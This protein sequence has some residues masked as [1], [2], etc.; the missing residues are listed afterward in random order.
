MDDFEGFLRR[1]NGVAQARQLLPGG[2]DVCSFGAQGVQSGFDLL[3]FTIQARDL[4]GQTFCTGRLLGAFCNDPERCIAFGTQ[5]A[6]FDQQTVKLALGIRLIRLQ[7]AD[8]IRVEFA[9]KRVDL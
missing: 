7:S 6:Q 2:V 1:R 8:A 9:P 5:G 4:D 3:P